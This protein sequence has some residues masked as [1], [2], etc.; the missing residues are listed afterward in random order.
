MQKLKLNYLK[1]LRCLI[2]HDSEC[3][4]IRNLCNN[5]LKTSQIMM[6]VNQLFLLV[7]YSLYTFIYMTQKLPISNYKFVSKFNKIEIY[8]KI[9]SI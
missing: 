8:S 2:I 1:I 6:M 3:I 9:K 7:M 4:F 5:L